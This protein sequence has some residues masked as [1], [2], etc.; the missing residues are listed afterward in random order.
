[1]NVVISSQR[2]IEKIDMKL[3]S[4]L[5]YLSILCNSKSC[6][7]DFAIQERNVVAKEFGILLTTVAQK[8]E[9]IEIII[10]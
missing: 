5:N 6:F 7:Y 9:R 1:M 4:W 8:R 10:F 3:K 2:G